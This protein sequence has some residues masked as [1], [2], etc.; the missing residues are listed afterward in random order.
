MNKRINNDQNIKNLKKREILRIL[1]IIFSLLTI[2]FALGNLFYNVNLL[3][4][5]FCFIVTVIFNK[6]REKTVIVKKDNIKEIRQ[7]IKKNKKKFK[8]IN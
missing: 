7:E 3:F 1:I 8:K 6:I 2:I 4:A 5:L